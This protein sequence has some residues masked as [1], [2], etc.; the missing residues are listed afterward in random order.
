MLS[1]LCTLCN[2]Q[3]AGSLCKSLSGKASAVAV[4][5]SSQLSCSDSMLCCVILLHAF[6]SSPTDEENIP[7]LL[8]HAFNETH[9]SPSRA[10]N[11][12]AW[13]F[14]TLGDLCV[15]VL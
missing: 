7:V 3:A 5:R 9:G 13:F 4:N 6:D 12:N 2:G 11:H 8:G 14:H 10:K 1:M 15:H